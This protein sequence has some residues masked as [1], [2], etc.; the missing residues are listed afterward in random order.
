MPEY[1]LLFGYAAKDGLVR[2]VSN[3]TI[4]EKILWVRSFLLLINPRKNYQQIYDLT[5]QL[6][7]SDEVS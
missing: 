4:N 3:R 5:I 6:L 1:T 2:I 7:L